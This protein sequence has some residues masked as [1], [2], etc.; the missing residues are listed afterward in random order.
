MRSANTGISAV[1]NEKGEVLQQSKWDEAICIE[2]KVNLNN[3]LTFYSQYG[4]YIG[5]LSLF[6]ATI[7]LFVTFVRIRLKE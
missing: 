4:D 6:V 1:F 3:E 5:R 7:L 2:A